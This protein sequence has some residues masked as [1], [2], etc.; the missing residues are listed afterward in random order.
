M[1]FPRHAPPAQFFGDSRAGHEIQGEVPLWE[2]NSCAQIYCFLLFLHTTSLQCRGLCVGASL[3]SSLRVGATTLQR[4]RLVERRGGAAGG[5]AQ[6]AGRARRQPG[7]QCCATRPWAYPRRELNVST[8]AGAAPSASLGGQGGLV[9]V[10][11]GS[12]KGWHR[13][14]FLRPPGPSTHPWGGGTPQKSHHPNP[15]KILGTL[16]PNPY[17]GFRSGTPTPQGGGTGSDPPPILLS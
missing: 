11:V 5:G 1:N 13:A 16:R 17:P 3:S 6:R 10:T 15:Q 8:V 9:L 2:H 4:S 12:R 14:P 7:P